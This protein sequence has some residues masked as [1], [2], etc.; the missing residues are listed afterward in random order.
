MELCD[1]NLEDYIQRK[2]PRTVNERIDWFVIVDQLDPNHR[3]GQYWGIMR[4]IANGIAY[5]HSKGE[6]HRD[7]KPRNGMCKNCLFPDEPL[8]L[9]LCREKIWKIADFG[10][11]AQVTSKGEHKTKYSRGT[12]CYRAPELIT[13]DE[14]HFYTNKVDIWAMGCVLYAIVFQKKAFTSDLAVLQYFMQRNSSITNVPLPDENLSHTFVDEPS[15]AAV[16]KVIQD[17]LA[18]DAFKRPSATKLYDLF[19]SAYSIAMFTSRYDKMKT[20][21][22]EFERLRETLDNERTIILHGLPGIGKSKI[23]TQYVSRFG[24]AYDSVLLL[25]APL[26]AKSMVSA[27]QQS[28][29]LGDQS[30]VTVESVGD[31]SFWED[32]VVHHT[33]WLVVIDLNNHSK[34]HELTVACLNVLIQSQVHVLVVAQ[35]FHRVMYPKMK[36]CGWSIHLKGFPRTEAQSLID[37]LSWEEHLFHQ[38][39]MAESSVE[40][41]KVG[42]GHPGPVRSAI[43]VGGDLIETITI[44]QNLQRSALFDVSLSPQLSACFSAP[45]LDTMLTVMDSNWPGSVGCLFLLSFLDHQNVSLELLASLVECWGLFNFPLAPPN[46]RSPSLSS[47]SLAA[48]VQSFIDRALQAWEECSVIEWKSRSNDVLSVDPYVLDVVLYRLTC[49]GPRPDGRFLA[50][51]CWKNARKAVERFCSPHSVVDSSSFETIWHV[52]KLVDVYKAD[53]I[54]GLFPPARF[55]KTY[56]VMQNVL[57]N[58]DFDPKLEGINSDLISEVRRYVGTGTLPARYRDRSRSPR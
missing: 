40:L 50:L 10:L 46:E 57:Q 33:D 12:P 35:S 9:Y 36:V 16:C 49:S 47:A 43:A 29:P 45:I 38:N 52:T 25:D 2:W 4:D 15:K 7:L 3:Q 54:L 42:N 6:I 19:S 1:L 24:D 48:H 41:I 21:H 23:A 27:F 13:E 55:P 44:L 51:K 28:I 18:T 31:T 26:V 30:K 22:N 37:L 32:W 8:V 20:I 39:L 34:L 56:G 53:N 17:M 5:I 58:R 11:T 14:D